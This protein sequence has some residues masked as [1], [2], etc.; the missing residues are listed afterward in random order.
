MKDFYVQN[1]SKEA[2]YICLRS[3]YWLTGECGGL[4]ECLEAGVIQALST[5]YVDGLFRC[6]TRPRSKKDWQCAAKKINCECIVQ[7]ERVEAD[8][9]EVKLHS[10]HDMWEVV[11]DAGGSP[12]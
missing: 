3:R 7:R 1:K 8:G 11:Q 4:V 2:M 6:K 9:K 5:A 12:F 10:H